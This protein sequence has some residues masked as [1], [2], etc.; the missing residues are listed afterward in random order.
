MR[1]LRSQEL[2][3]SS[4]SHLW[5]GICQAWPATLKRLK[6]VV[7]DGKHT[8]FLRDKWLYD[9]TLSEEAIFL[10]D[11]FLQ[12]RKVDDYVTLNGQQNWNL[13]SS[14]LPNFPL[15]VF[16]GIKCLEVVDGPNTFLA[17]NGVRRFQ[18]QVSL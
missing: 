1:A 3:P 6:W 12:E 18:C 7:M 5:H 14:I 2:T 16:E 4:F 11:G 10:G 8:D 17:W 13:I 9:F 15:E